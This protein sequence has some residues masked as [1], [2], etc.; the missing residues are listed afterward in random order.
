MPCQGYQN[1]SDIAVFGDHFQTRGCGLKGLTGLN[2]LP[3]CFCL[4]H[5]WKVHVLLLRKISAVGLGSL[6]RTADNLVVVMM[7]ELLSASLAL[8]RNNLYL[9][10]VM[11]KMVCFYSKK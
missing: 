7:L 5:Q 2:T 6:R 8:V 4:Q 9:R 11:L 3:F 1:W 10:F